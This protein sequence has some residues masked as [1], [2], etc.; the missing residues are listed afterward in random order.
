[1]KRIAIVVNVAVLVSAAAAI[2]VQPNVAAGQQSAFKPKLSADQQLMKLENEWADAMVKRDAAALDGILANDYTGTNADGIVSTKAQYL[3][4]LKSGKD[5]ISSLVLD[6][7]RVRVYGDTA[8]VT[9]RSTAKEVSEG[10]D[11]STQFRWTDMWVKD[12]AGRWQCV[13][14]HSSNIAQK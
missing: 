13:A 3:A 2:L 7:M 4:S 6:D 5:V 12:Y 9:G 1:M 14:S 8:V 11:I 10:K